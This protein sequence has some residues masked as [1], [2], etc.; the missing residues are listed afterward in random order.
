MLTCGLLLVS[1]PEPEEIESGTHQQVVHPDGTDGKDDRFSAQVF[2]S[3][4]EPRAMTG[5]PDNWVRRRAEQIGVSRAR[6]AIDATAPVRNRI[7]A[8]QRQLVLL[9]AVYTRTKNL[10]DAGGDVGQ[11]ARRNADAF[12]NGEQRKFCQKWLL[13]VGFKTRCALFYRRLLEFVP[14][15]P[16]PETLCCAAALEKKDS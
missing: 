16:T 14:C 7:N 6:Q 3:N 9:R 2:E 11:E 10:G 12:L 5:R 15:S 8:W 1:T 4:G 13:T